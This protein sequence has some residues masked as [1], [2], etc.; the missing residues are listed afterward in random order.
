MRK[1]ECKYN[2]FV[3]TNTPQCILSIVLF[4]FGGAGFCLCSMVD[5]EVMRVEGQGNDI[6]VTTTLIKNT[7]VDTA[8]SLF[9]NEVTLVTHWSHRLKLPGGTILTRLFPL[10]KCSHRRRKHTLTDSDYLLF[11]VWHDL[12]SYLC[13]Q[14]AALQMTTHLKELFVRIYWHDLNYLSWWF[15]M[16]W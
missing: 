16:L 12:L 4:F 9:S 14:R 15:I 2:L 3:Y 11:W 7:L 1:R 10:W 13:V 8:V 5:R 6:Q